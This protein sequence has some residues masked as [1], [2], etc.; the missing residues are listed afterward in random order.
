MGGLALWMTIASGYRVAAEASALPNKVSALPRSGR[1]CLF[2][3]EIV[4]C[5]ANSSPPGSIPVGC[6][7]A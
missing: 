1:K 5:H 2:Q 4:T 3:A 6:R 7:S